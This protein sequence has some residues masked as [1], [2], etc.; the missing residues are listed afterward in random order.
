MATFPLSDTEI[1]EGLAK[2]SFDLRPGSRETLRELFGA[3]FEDA[4]SD[5]SQY[6]REDGAWTVVTAGAGN[7]LLVPITFAF[8]RYK[9]SNAVTA[10]WASN[11]SPPVLTIITPT[12]MDPDE[13]ML[14]GFQAHVSDIVDGAGFTITVYTNAGYSGDLNVMCVGV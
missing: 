14:Y 2:A 10:T 7:K 1:R 6:A 9:A 8:D 12:G 5:G 4:P 3:V 13:M 11:T